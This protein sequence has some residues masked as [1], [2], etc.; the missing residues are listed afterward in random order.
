ML[1][2]NTC[3]FVAT[4]IYPE[5]AWKDMFVRYNEGDA[6]MRIKTDVKHPN[7][8]LREF[9]AFR[10]TTVRTNKAGNVRTTGYSLQPAEKL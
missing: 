9:P 4:F 3:W 7:P 1:I 10:I 5:N 6:V 2:P 8:A